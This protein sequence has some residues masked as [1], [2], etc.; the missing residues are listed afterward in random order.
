M[1]AGRSQGR[2]ANDVA[3]GVDPFHIRLV[4]L[5][6]LDQAG[7]IGGKA[8]SIEIEGLDVRYATRGDQYTFRANRTA[9]LEV[10]DAFAIAILIFN[11]DSADLLLLHHPNTAVAHGVAERVENVGVEVEQ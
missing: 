2:K 1:H 11:T 8:N 6:D 5:V 4:V 3:D 10:D 7:L 9:A